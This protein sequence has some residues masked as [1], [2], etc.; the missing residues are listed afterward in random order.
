VECIISETVISQY[1]S[2]ATMYKNGQ[3]EE[4]SAETIATDGNYHFITEISAG[5][6]LVYHAACWTSA[7]RAIYL[8]HNRVKYLTRA[9]VNTI[10]YYFEV[11]HPRCVFNFKYIFSK[12]VIYNIYVLYFVYD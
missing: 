9:T 5:F 2:M 1:P 4:L 3:L 10:Y 11:T 7:Q 6:K 12:S 8:S